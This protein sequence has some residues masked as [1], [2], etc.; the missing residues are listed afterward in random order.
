MKTFWIVLASIVVLLCGVFIGCE[1]YAQTHDYT[2]TIE[3]V[4]DWSM[5]KK[6][7]PTETDPVEAEVA[8]NALIINF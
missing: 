2:N 8:E 1:I 7:T 5:F 6:D 4:K 3:W